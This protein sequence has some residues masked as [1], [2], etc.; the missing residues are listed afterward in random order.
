MASLCFALSPKKFDHCG[1]GEKKNP[2]LLGRAESRP[3]M[4]YLARTL[5]TLCLVV[6]V[7]KELDSSAV[8]REWDSQIPRPLLLRGGGRGPVHSH[9]RMGV[10]KKRRATAEI[11]ES[12]EI[13]D[14]ESEDEGFKQTRKPASSKSKGKTAESLFDDMPD[15]EDLHSARAFEHGGR[16]SLFG[17][18]SYEDGTDYTQHAQNDAQHVQRHPH[19]HGPGQGEE[20]EEGEGEDG[21]DDGDEG[22]CGVGILLREDAKKGLVVQSF[23]EGGPAALHGGIEKGDILCE[24]D[25]TPCKRLNLYQVLPFTFV[26]VHMNP[27][28]GHTAHEAMHVCMAV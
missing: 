23:A 9:G 25:G 20:E 28:Y 6:L 27:M 8:P 11:P 14:S 22:L 3:C 10:H 7:G 5:F 12:E 4:I 2:S 21:D 19:L 15:F 1:I 13:E 18:N 16:S 26:N 17:A 24:I